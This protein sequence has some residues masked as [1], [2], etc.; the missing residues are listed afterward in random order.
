MQ[1]LNKEAADAMIQVGVNACTDITGFG[2][3]GHLIRM[4]RKSNMTASLYAPC[5]PTFQ[6]VLE[7]IK[8]GVIPGAIERNSEFVGRDISIGEGVEE[9]SKYIGFDAQTSGGLL[10]AVAPDKKDKLVEELQSHGV[11]PYIIGKITGPSNGRIELV[12]SQDTLKSHSLSKE[13]QKSVISSM[14]DAEEEHPGSQCCAEIIDNTERNKSSNAGTAQA[15]GQAFNQLIKSISASGTLDE[16]TKELIIFSLT[17]NSRCEACVVLHYEKAL[18]MGITKQ[19]L[20]EAAWCA[21]AMGGAPVK[22]FYTQFQ[23]KQ[24]NG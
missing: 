7:L 17:V 4:L 13:K 20:N 11:T 2:L 24:N 3:F 5:L 18:R 9:A 23:N 14:P 21:I 8:E 10:I 19:E 6:G 1:T 16:R 12:A 22:M 15:S